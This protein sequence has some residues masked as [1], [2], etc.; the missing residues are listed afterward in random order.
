MSIGKA[1]E[2]LF[3][4]YHRAIHDKNVRKPLAWA[5]YHTWLIVDTIEKERKT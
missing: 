2:Y 1:V 3:E 4:M 5:L